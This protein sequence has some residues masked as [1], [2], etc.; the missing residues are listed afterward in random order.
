VR[1]GG[2]LI[3]ECCCGV[4]VPQHSKTKEALVA[5]LLSELLKLYWTAQ[6]ASTFVFC[7]KR[8]TLL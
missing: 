5:E 4:L 3:V 8:V 7:E 2:E 6:L 1:S